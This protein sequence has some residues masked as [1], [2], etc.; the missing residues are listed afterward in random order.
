MY[1]LLVPLLAIALSAGLLAGTPPAE[2][3]ETQSLAVIPLPVAQAC[4]GP[5]NVL[6]A[7]S[8]FVFTTSEPVVFRWD[9]NADGVLDSPPR[10]APGA[11]HVYPDEF[12]VTARIV[13][14][15]A[16]GNLSAAVTAFGTLTCP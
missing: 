16:E 13:A 7:L 15:N 8:A 12:P 5:D 10:L 9:F 1:R 11:L 3:A 4:L 2:S 6:V 14:R